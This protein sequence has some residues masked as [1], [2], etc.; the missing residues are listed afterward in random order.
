MPL[1]AGTKLGPYEIL[2]PIGAGG[3][4]EVY[5]AR[6]TRLDR[7]V[8]IKVSKEQFSERFEREAR[9]IASLNHPHICSLYDVGPNFLVME[10][11]QG[12]P[13][14][15][16][17][18]TA[19][20]V[21]WALQIA[22][23]I[24]AAHQ[25]NIVHRD[26]KP[27]N[28]LLT[29]A[30]LKL[31]DFGLAKMG[32]DASMDSE[33][34]T[35]TMLTE[36]GTAM[37]TVAYMSPEQARGKIVDGRTDLW[38]LGVVLYELLAGVRPFEGGTTAVVFEGL[39]TKDPVPIRERN[40]NVPATLEQIIERLLQ[41]DAAL[42]YQTAAEL[43]DD[44][45][46]LA[47][48]GPKARSWGK[49]GIAA[50]AVLVVVAGGVLVWQRMPT[51]ALTDKDVLVLADFTNSTG[52]PVFD[53]TLREGLA[54]QL[55]QSRFLKIMDEEQVQHNLQLM[56]LPREER[57]TNQI[58]RDI[59]LR[60]GAEAMI[61]GSI[62]S[63]GKNYVLSLQATTCQD[64]K[65]LARE[66]IPAEDKEHVLNALGTGATAMRSKLGESFSSIQRSNR[67]LEQATTSSM[68]A[69]QTY[70]AGKAQV[71]QGHFLAAVPL[72]QRAVALDKNFAMANSVLAIAFTA[73]GDA[74]R[75]REYS[76]KAF[77]LI[78]R[79]TEYERNY[80]AAHYYGDHGEFDKA[81]DAYQ[82]ANRNYPRDW[83]FPNNLSEIL[84]NTGQFEEGLKEGLESLRLQPNAE[85]PYRRLLD[86]YMCLDRLREA[87]ELAP[88]VRALGLDGARIHQRFLEMAYIEGDQAAVAREIQW[89]AGKP[90]EYLSF[91]LQAAY[92]NVQGQRRESSKLYQRAAETALRQGLRSA[93][94]EVEEADAHADA[95]AGNCLTAHRL[96]RPA[97]ALALCGD[98]AEAEKLAE[99]TSKASAN[100]TIWNAVQLPEIRAAIELH[101]DHP[102]KAVDLLA[103]A[104]PYERAFPGAVYLRGLAYLRL[105]NGADAAAEFHR[106]LDHKGANWGTDWRHPYWGQYYSLSY[107]GL[108]RASV[109]AGDAATARKAFDDFFTLWKDADQDVPVLSAARQEYAALK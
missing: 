100:E 104:S 9:A 15:G 80:I 23:A 67:P 56:R 75:S 20:A 102:A 33:A 86:V 79:V 4:G 41:K 42:R 17:V 57:I 1:P 3:M 18:A 48:P 55:E 106:V 72:L 83:I 108:A 78:D 103:S 38:S 99:E 93:A 87:E 45:Q 98:S 35:K 22:D 34:W 24:D 5:C 8:A 31:L 60:D 13:L 19:E 32:A 16:P 50:A 29:K 49:F 6:D 36:P 70:T 54:I 81:I 46:R 69:L 63:L 21:R 76:A 47:E 77:A 89:Y 39:L 44:L 26:L 92:R 52:D 43:R 68:E 71:T 105:K 109:L 14:K 73:A 7:L 97:L 95:L 37:G 58:A 84:I 82:L 66:Q 74:G 12:E 101:L 88:K 64:G 25:K 10:Y 27:A 65:T 94:Q 107:L 40:P 96:G 85:G 53:G 2:A 61:E 91:G 59:C 51:K 30:G 90:V 62:A 11:I 28:I